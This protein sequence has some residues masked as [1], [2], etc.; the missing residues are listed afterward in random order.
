VLGSVQMA[1]GKYEEAAAS[2]R[3]SVAAAP[4]SPQFSHNLARAELAQQRA[5]E[6]KEVLAETLGRHPDY[7]PVISALAAIEMREGN[8]KQ[9]LAR[10]R[11][12]QLDPRT[13]AA[14][15]SLEGDLYMMQR[16]FETAARAYDNTSAQ[17]RTAML[18]IKSYRARKQAKMPDA[19]KPLQ[20]WLSK[21]PDDAR[22]RLALAEGYQARGQVKEAA[23]EYERV[24]KSYPDN[25]ATLN[26]LA[27]VY[28]EA[29]DPRAIQLAERAHTLMPENGAITDTFGWLLV[30]EGQAQRGL[31]LLRKAAAQ[32]PDVPDIRYH[33]AVAL[34]KTGA[35]EEARSTLAALLD[36]GQSFK[37]MA[38]AKQ[39][40]QQL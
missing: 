24:L 5:G 29:N 19:V 15:H 22:V 38:D 25:P 20:E 33:L 1:D 16:Q 3:R 4:D 27:W 21:H 7:I 31:E 36:S 12:L 11:T 40:L 23:V 2:F 9:A 18:A 35:K 28:Y 14:G 37:D 32:A 17:T 6:A 39:L 34:A 8:A 30:Q 10:A 13:A 26:N